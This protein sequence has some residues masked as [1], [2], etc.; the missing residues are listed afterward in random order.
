M[1]MKQKQ[2]FYA[3]REGY[4]IGV[5]TDWAA[6]K[7]Q[8]DGYSGAVYKSFLTEKEA[9]AFIKGEE[10]SVKPQE[11]TAVA[12]VDGSYLHSARKFSFGAVLFFNGEE[13][14][15]KEAYDDAELAQ[16][17]NVAGEIKGAEFIMQYCAEHSIPAVKIYYDYAGIEKWCT[18]EWQANKAGTKA[19]KSSFERYSKVVD[20]SFCK[21]KGHSG[22]RYND[23]VDRLAKSALGIEG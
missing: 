7:K 10:I 5:F 23:L 19:Y 16:M 15:F 14:L 9:I 6:C 4:Q 20:I 8:V 2:K 13:K 21:V 11:N 12:Y 1:K 3:V 18:G 22:D 17:R